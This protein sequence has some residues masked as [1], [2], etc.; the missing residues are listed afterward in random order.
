MNNSHKPY[1]PYEH[2][3]KRP[4]DFSLALT[5]L[6][7]LAPIFIILTI[8]GAFIMRGNPFFVQKRP[9]RINTKSG[10][11]KIFYLIKF[12]TM[13]NAKDKDGN[14]LP[15]DKRLCFYG[16][17]LRSTSCDELPELLNIIKGDM[18]IVGPRPL[19]VNYLPYYSFEERKRHT[20]RPGLTGL[21]QVNGRNFLQWDDR[22]ALDVEYSQNVSFAN[23][24]KIILKT[25]V[26]VVKR[27]DISETRI[28]PLDMARREKE[29][30]ISS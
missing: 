29:N 11:E 24:V 18:A 1:G 9:G 14:L 6:V 26:K 16:R 13:S 25:I 23:D 10:Q 30:A 19:L 5:A 2:F 20:V 8:I 4:L 17:I 28:T 12:R 7:I 22:L 15:D 27:S 21:A 3:F